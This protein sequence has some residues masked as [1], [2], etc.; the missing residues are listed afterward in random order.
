MFFWCPF[1][2]KLETKDERIKLRAYVAVDLTTSSSTP[3]TGLT[4]KLRPYVHKLQNVKFHLPQP[5]AYSS[6]GSWGHLEWDGKVAQTAGEKTFDGALMSWARW[7]DSR[8][9]YRTKCLT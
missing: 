6:V 7:I 2:V 8:L 3:G 4:A 9:Q 5:T 1:L